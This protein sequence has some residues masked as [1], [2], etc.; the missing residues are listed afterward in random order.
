M[1]NAS[2]GWDP[3]DVKIHCGLDYT[4]ARFD[5]NILKYVNKIWYVKRI[6]YGKLLRQNVFSRA[7]TN[8][9]EHR[10]CRHRAEKKWSSKDVARTA[11]PGK[12]IAVSPDGEQHPTSSLIASPPAPTRSPRSTAACSAPARDAALHAAAGTCRRGPP[13]ACPCASRCNMKG[14]TQICAQSVL[15]TVAWPGAAA[16]SPDSRPPC[17]RGGRSARRQPALPSSR[18]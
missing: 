18:E 13:T 10:S 7:D 4:V 14:G 5:V 16:G 6:K 12:P 17:L 11:S 8:R 9:G 2:S 15:R 1:T 3:G